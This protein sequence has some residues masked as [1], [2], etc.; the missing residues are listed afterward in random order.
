MDLRTA[1][2]EAYNVIK[3]GGVILYPTASQW[4]LGCDA[5]NAEAIEKINAIKN[6]PE[7]KSFLCLVDSVAMLERS[8]QVVPDAAYDLIDHASRPTTII[9]DQPTGVAQNLL[10][11]DGSL[12]IRVTGSE[13]CKRL[14]QRM[15]G[16]L[17]S[18]SANLAGQPAPTGL[19]DIDE[20]IRDAVDYIVN[21]PTEQPSGT[22][23]TIIKLTDS[24]V[25]TIIRP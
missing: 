12:G 9:Y 18:T 6:R 11:P 23:S 10:A 13:F 22:A 21:L 19:H 16:P 2:F 4:G 5:R 15:R 20:S 25:I 24:S 14:I 17:V 8:V 1:V 7:G 3:E